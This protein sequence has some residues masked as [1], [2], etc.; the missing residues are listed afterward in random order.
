MEKTE[1]LIDAV[2]E[3]IQIDVQNE[4]MTALAELLTHVPEEYLIGFLS[5]I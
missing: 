5:N 1:G 3:Q 2:I 4:D